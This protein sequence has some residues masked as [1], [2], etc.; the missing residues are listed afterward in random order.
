MAA[1]APA[2]SCPRIVPMPQAA[3][4]KPA[5]A[6]AFSNFRLTCLIAYNL[7]GAFRSV[8]AEAPRAITI[9]L[10]CYL[11]VSFK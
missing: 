9:M 10:D 7:I 5:T 8:S 2:A 3:H 6:G 11:K 4:S 1:T